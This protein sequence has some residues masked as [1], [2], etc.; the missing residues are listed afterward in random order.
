LSA[1]GLGVKILISK[2]L[3]VLWGVASM[4]PSPWLSSTLE[5]GWRKVRCHIEAVNF[6][7]LWAELVLVNGPNASPQG[8]KP[9]SLS[10]LARRGLKPRPFKAVARS[11]EAICALFK[12]HRQALVCLASTFATSNASEKARIGSISFNM[13]QS[14]SE[15][16]HWQLQKFSHAGVIATALSSAVRP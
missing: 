12:D 10:G 16:R 13:R 4:P 5:S 1:L 7:V 6:L 11:F 8:L 2:A 9:G 14:Q 15:P 3:G